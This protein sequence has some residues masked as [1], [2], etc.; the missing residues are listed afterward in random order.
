MRAHIYILCAHTQNSTHKHTHTQSAGI[1]GQKREVMRINAP[2]IQW[3]PQEQLQEVCVR[4]QLICM[5]VYV[6]VCMRAAM[7]GACKTSVDMYVR[8][9]VG[10]YA[11][12]YVCT[13]ICGCI[14]YERYV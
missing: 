10:V 9:Y 3:V 2:A 11:S 12:S 5:Y 13:C 14:C 8:V 1:P 4:P 7:R 6:C